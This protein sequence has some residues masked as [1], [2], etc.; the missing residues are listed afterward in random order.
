MNSFEVIR[1]LPFLLLSMADCFIQRKF[2]KVLHYSSIEIA[3]ILILLLRVETGVVLG[4]VTC[5]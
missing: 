1:V 3:S 2:L 5:N 4:H